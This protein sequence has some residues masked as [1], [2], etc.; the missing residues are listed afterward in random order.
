MRDLDKN[1]SKPDS[2]A[3]RDATIRARSGS[4]LE[5]EAPREIA[6]EPVPQSDRHELCAGRDEWKSHT[7]AALRTLFGEPDERDFAVRYWDG[8][9]EGPTGNPSL[10]LV[11]KHPGAL[12][13]MLLP[14]TELSVTEAYIRDDIDVEGELERATHLGDVMA[15]RIRPSI[16]VRRILPH[17]LA[18][19]AGR[20]D[21]AAGSRRRRW[22]L[23]RQHS[24]RRDRN[25]VRYHYDVGNE[26]FALFLDERLIYSCAY[27]ETGTESLEAAQ[28]AKLEHTCRKLRLVPGERLLDIGCGW[29]GLILHAAQRY[30]VNALGITLSEPQAQLARQRIAAAGLSDR[31]RVEVRDYRELGSEQAFDKI[32]SIGMVEHVGHGAVGDYFG[33]AYR[34]LR[35]GGLFLSHGITTIAGARPKSL[36]TRVKDWLWRGRGFI[37]HY[38]FPDSELLPLGEH[39]L[40]AERAGFESR[41]AES[42]REHY[43]LTLRHWVRRLEANHAEAVRLA[44]EATYRVWRLYM[45]AAAHQFARGRINVEQLLLAKPDAVG[46]SGVPLTRGDLYGG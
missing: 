21:L 34:V 31:C 38:V 13:R 30:G 23:A 3:T 9:I 16:F 37:K 27:F 11:L 36:A 10:T 25:A 8:T 41:D 46:R 1:P 17:L 26:F 40:A 19:P 43:A 20:P 18:L 24:L 45:S 7:S 5:V 4:L 14:P 6:H 32:V 2:T 39:V 42:L 15:L 35:S 28:Q 33:Q 44:G 12:R 22:A 29:G